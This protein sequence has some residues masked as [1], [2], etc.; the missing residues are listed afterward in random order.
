MIVTTSEPHSTPRVY[1]LWL[2]RLYFVLLAARPSVKETQFNLKHNVTGPYLQSYYRG[3]N[4]DDDNG[5]E[6]ET[7]ST[8]HC[9]C[10]NR[11]KRRKKV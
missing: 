11:T 6:D 3:Y 4:E 8:K 1:S 2:Y 9:T 5:H 7:S 10:T